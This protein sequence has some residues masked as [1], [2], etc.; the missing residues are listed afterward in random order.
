MRNALL[1]LPVKDIDIATT[2]TPRQTIAAAKK[3]GL[4]TIETGLAHG[5]VTVVANHTPFEVTTLRR[6]EETD[7]RRARVA[8]T[9]DWTEDAS[10]RDFTINA[11]YCGADGTLFDPLAGYGDLIERRVCFIGNAEDRIREDTLRILRFFRF[12]S[13]YAE[14]RTEPAGYKACVALKDGIK[15]LSGERR[16][17]EMLRILTTPFAAGIA[18]IMEA[19]G[20]LQLAIGTGTKAAIMAQVIKLEMNH[21]SA[22]DALLRLGAVALAKPGDARI[23]RQSLKLSSNEF[24][25]LARMAMPDR[26][27]DPASNE[28]DAKAFIYRHGAEAFR[29]GVLLAWAQSGGNTPDGD[30]LERFNLTQRW[31]APELPVRGADILAL[32]IPPG[33]EVGRILSDFEDWWIAAGFPMTPALLAKRLERTIT[34]TKP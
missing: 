21:G 3:A 29:D 33:P 7:G 34:V 1:G 31:R 8:F 23:L 9:S 32:G 2:A 20:I 28:I 17:V 5:T 12:T 19:C 4:K 24:E 26:A 16:R 15:T 25:R 22:P 18:S 30:W 6:D 14:G 11:L 13:E 10:R 27:F